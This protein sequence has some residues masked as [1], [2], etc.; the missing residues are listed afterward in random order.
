[1][2]FASAS[3]LAGENRSEG[4]IFRDSSVE[5][6]QKVSSV[7]LEGY[8]P[9]VCMP[10]LLFG[11]CPKAVHKDNE[12]CRCSSS[13]SRNSADNLSGR[14][15]VY[16]SV[17]GRPET[18]Y[19]YGTVHSNPAVGVSRVSSKYSGNDSAPARLQGGSNKSPLHP[20]ASASRSFSPGAIPADGKLTASIQAIFPAPLHYRHL[21]HLKHQA[22]AQRKGYD[23][24]IA[25]SIE[26]REELHLNAWNGRALPHPSHQGSIMCP[27]ETSHG[28]HFGSS[29]C[30][31]SRGDTLPRSIQ[32]VSSSLGM[33]FELKYFSERQTPFRPPE[34]HGRLAVQTLQPF[35]QLA[36]V[37]TGVSRSDADSRAMCQR[38]FCGQTECSVA[39]VFQLDAR[40][41]SDCLGCP[42]TGLVVREK[43][44]FPSVL[45]DNVITSEVEGT[46]GRVDTS[47]SFGANASLVPQ[48]VESVSIPTSS[49]PYEPISVTRGEI[50]PLIATKNIYLEYFVVALACFWN[51]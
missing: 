43:L 23:A 18:G 20:L 45:P 37:S 36:V 27:C 25:L 34:C 12:T 47:H 29:L 21:Q 50:H 30:E 9:R 41:K 7:Y 38:P 24:T 33:G 48:P 39:S 26:A 10:P 15:F 14:S 49:S 16:E 44:C 19:G 3:G 22:L 32:P 6:S 4:C 17:Q 5:T 1:M 40:S 31:P 51:N 35:E 11:H 42:S 28:Q 46:R 8:T 2:R 13:P